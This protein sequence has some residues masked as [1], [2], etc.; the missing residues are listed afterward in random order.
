MTVTTFSS[1][2]FDHDAGRARDAAAAGPVFI[3]HDGQPAHV[4]LSIEAYRRITRQTGNLFDDLGLPLG[5]EDI[6]I[7][8]HSSRDLPRPAEIV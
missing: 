7:D 3:T 6:E 5:V 4:L 1:R 2:E 8:F